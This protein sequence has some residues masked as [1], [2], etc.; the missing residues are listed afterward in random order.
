MKIKDLKIHLFFLKSFLEIFKKQNIKELNPFFENF[1]S[2]NQLIEILEYLYLDG[3]EEFKIENLNDKELLD[4]I[5]N[6]VSLLEYYIFK[7]EESITSTPTMSQEEVSSFF[8]EIQMENYYLA[9]KPV[10]EWDEYDKSNYYSL[11]LKRG[12]SK[13]VFAIF[14]SDVNDEDKYAVTTKPSFFFDT[15]EDAELELQR[16]L[17]RENFKEDDLKIMSLWKIH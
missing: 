1:F 12:K 15:K 7:L 14:T 8:K 4:L 16:I 13:R 10:N 3:L 9:D 5:G 17:T 6:D 2:R 11:L